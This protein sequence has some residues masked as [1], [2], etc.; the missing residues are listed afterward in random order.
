[1]TATQADPHLTAR[2]VHGNQDEHRKTHE[3]KS[4]VALAAALLVAQLPSLVAILLQFI[5]LLFGVAYC[6]VP[7]Y[8]EFGQGVDLDGTLDR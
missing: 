6:F 7:R 3:M 2:L 8:E 4:S 5:N 1:M